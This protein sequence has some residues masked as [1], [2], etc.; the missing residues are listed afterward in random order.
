[1]MLNMDKL[2]AMCIQCNFDIQYGI[3]GSAKNVQHMKYL[4]AMLSQVKSRDLARYA[5]GRISAPIY[6]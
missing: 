6:Y 4:G 5:R 3:G 2:E 1:M